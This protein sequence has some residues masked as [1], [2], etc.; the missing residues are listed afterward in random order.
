MVPVCACVTRLP[1]VIVGIC[2]CAAQGGTISR[3]GK[4]ACK[5]WPEEWGCVG[6]DNTYAAVEVVV[7]EAEVMVKVEVEAEI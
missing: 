3:S 7:G 4:W 1:V 2:W 5:E 6:K